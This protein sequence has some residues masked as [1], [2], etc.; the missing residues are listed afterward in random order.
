MNELACDGFGFGKN[1]INSHLPARASVVSW[2]FSKCFSFTLQK[3]KIHVCKQMYTKQM[4]EL[5]LFLLSPL[6]QSYRQDGN[7]KRTRNQYPDPQ[8]GGRAINLQ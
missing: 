5:T 1:S 8:K 6:L 3:R 4:L 2:N 7:C